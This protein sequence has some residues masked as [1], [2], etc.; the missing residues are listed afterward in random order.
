M[1]VILPYLDQHL[2]PCGDFMPYDEHAAELH[3]FDLAYG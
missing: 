1:T 3:Y 2:T